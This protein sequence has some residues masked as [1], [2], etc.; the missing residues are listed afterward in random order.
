MGGER[1]SV[2]LTLFLKKKKVVKR[3]RGQDKS[4]KK[5]SEILE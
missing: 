4:R 2:K 1:G 5:G 3:R